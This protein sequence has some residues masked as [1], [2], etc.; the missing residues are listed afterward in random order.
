MVGRIT[1]ADIHTPDRKT[2]SHKPCEIQPKL[3]MTFICLF[4]MSWLISN[5]FSDA[6]TQ[7]LRSAFISPE[8]T[9]PRSL[10]LSS[11][12]S[13]N[14]PILSRG[15]PANQMTLTCFI[16]YK[17]FR[18]PLC[19]AGFLKENW[20]SRYITQPTLSLISHHNRLIAQRRSIPMPDLAAN[21]MRKFSIISK[22]IS[23]AQRSG[24][25]YRGLFSELNVLSFYQLWNWIKCRIAWQS[26]SNCMCQFRADKNSHLALPT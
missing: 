15:K 5:R 2:S 1:R 26:I 19:S 8:R 3:K 17:I 6:L 25:R 10:W 9:Q 16:N 23:C 18:T 13:N 14:Q 12:P 20:G 11:S 24:I 7:I 21:S 22:S 4:Q